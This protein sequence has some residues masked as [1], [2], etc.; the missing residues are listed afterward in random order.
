MKIGIVGDGRMAQAIAAEARAAGDTIVTILGAG[1][2]AA[3]FGIT[4]ERF[5]ACDVVFEFTVPDAAPANLEALHAIGATVVCGTT[6]WDDEREAIEQRWSNGPGALLIASNF[7]LGVQLFLRAAK[8]LAQAAAS[9]PEFDGF[10]HERHHAAKVD[11]PSGT[12]LLLQ[13]TARGADPTRAWPITSVR[14]GA[15][16]G[17][18]ELVLDGPFES[19]TLRHSARDRR[20]FAAGALTVARW[21]VGRRGT[22]TLDAMFAGD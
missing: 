5:G 13:R 3:G 7:S 1:E 8:A 22:F 15:I 19:I 9:R 21:L 2:N 17:D 14:A 6:G 18:H 20:V 4:R 12:G 11:A 10:L 16:P